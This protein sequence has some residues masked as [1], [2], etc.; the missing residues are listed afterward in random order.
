[1]NC[2][3]IEQESFFSNPLQLLVFQVDNNFPLGFSG[4]IQG[5]G[6]NP[7]LA[8]NLYGRNSVQVS[9]NHL[10]AQYIKKYLTQQDMEGMK[11]DAG[12]SQVLCGILMKTRQI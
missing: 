12:P 1:M 3:K 9:S 7:A 6:I 10:E 2:L 4:T 5:I 8:V 11:E